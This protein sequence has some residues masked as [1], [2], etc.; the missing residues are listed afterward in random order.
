LS[1]LFRTHVFTFGI[2]TSVIEQRA[3]QETGDEPYENATYGGSCNGSREDGRVEC[4]SRRRIFEGAI[5]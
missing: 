1:L 3:E 4:R 2:E 5:V